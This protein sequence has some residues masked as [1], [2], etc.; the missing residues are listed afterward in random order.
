MFHRPSLL[1]LAL[2]L[3]QGCAARP[4]TPPATVR[5]APE[6]D[7]VLPQPGTLGR[8]VNAT[9]LVSA[10]YGD[11]TITFEGHISARPDR[12]LLAVIDPLGRKAL[13]ITWTDQDIAYESA[14]WLPPKL[15]PENMLADLVVLY[16]PE[17]VVREAL[18]ASGGT[19]VTGPG[20]RSIM[21]GGREVIQAD[22]HMAAADPWTGRDHYR[23]LPRGY[24]L[25][26]ESVAQF[27]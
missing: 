2:L 13:T 5:I 1:L 15:R 10:H 14:P 7:L 22:Y 21:A 6:L 9:Q 17:A 27:P 18:R 26:I 12:F 16:W 3:L 8:S 25:D 20:T 19:V 24:D 4:A 11:Q 23:N